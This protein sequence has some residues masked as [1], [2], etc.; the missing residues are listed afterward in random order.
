MKQITQVTLRQKDGK[1]FQA[2]G[3]QNTQRSHSK[4]RGSNMAG[5]DLAGN[6]G[7]LT[8]PLDPNLKELEA[9]H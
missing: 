1:C 4:G 5:P 8:S 9:L 7:I 2:D 3:I 6:N